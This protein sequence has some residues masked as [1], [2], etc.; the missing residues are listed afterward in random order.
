MRFSKWSRETIQERFESQ[1]IPEPNSG[2]WLWTEKL[3]RDGYGRFCCGDGKTV[4]AHRFSWQSNFGDLN[5]DM[6]VCHT[7][8]VPCCV[9]PE[10]LFLG[11]HIENQADKFRKGRAARGEKI[12]ISKFVG[13][14]IIEMRELR[15]S[16][17]TFNDLGIKFDCAPSTAHRI[18]TNQGWKHIKGLS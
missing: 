15:K 6:N 16:G 17:L 2:C 9:N 7:C 1:F 4:S 8:D 14:Q 5:P 13:S 10:H 3:D 12:G 18:C 11:S